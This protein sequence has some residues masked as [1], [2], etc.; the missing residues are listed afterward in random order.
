MFT[1][2]TSNLFSLTGAS[3]ALGELGLLV[4]SVLLGIYLLLRARER[5]EYAQ[6]LQQTLY[7]EQHQK[8]EQVLDALTPPTA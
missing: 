4:L 3:E 7:Q 6:G 1:W 5:I 8:L 2:L